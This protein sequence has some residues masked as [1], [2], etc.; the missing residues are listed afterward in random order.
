MM[1]LYNFKCKTCNKVETKKYEISEF[2]SIKDKV[3]C[4]CNNKMVHIITKVNASVDKKG[5]EVMEDVVE[6]IAKLRQKIEDND[7]ATIRDIYGE[8]LNKE[9]FNV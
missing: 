5:I 7:E 3:I 4:S 1:P 8:E 6:D 2:L 9:K